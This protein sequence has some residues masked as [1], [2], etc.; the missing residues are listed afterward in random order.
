[1]KKADEKFTEYL[2]RQLERADEE[3]A[4]KRAK[5]HK[6][7]GDEEMKTEKVHEDKG[8]EE[9]KTEKVPDI[10]GDEEMRASEADRGA[11]ATSAASSGLT[12]EE[13]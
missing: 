5:V 6:D 13:R 10:K 12:G 9:M 4:L 11:K 8:D 2:A 3:R 7:K 1:M